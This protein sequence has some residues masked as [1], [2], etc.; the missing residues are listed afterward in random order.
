LFLFNKD[1]ME[2]AIA[3]AEGLVPQM[4]EPDPEQLEGGI[5]ARA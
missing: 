5:K 4:Y 1:N 3:M 2:G